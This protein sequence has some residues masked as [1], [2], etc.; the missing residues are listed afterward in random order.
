M[1][2]SFSISNYLFE[3]SS[4]EADI[5]VEKIIEYALR[6]DNKIFEFETWISHV[7]CRQ[8]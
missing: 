7:E 5:D 3:A 8:R 6:I 2:C 1:F 4:E